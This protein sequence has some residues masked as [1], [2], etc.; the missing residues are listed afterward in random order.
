M[1]HNNNTKIQNN[2]KCYNT[3][4]YVYID[5]PLEKEDQI[6]VMG[7]KVIPFEASINSTSFNLDVSNDYNN[8]DR[9]SSII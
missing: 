2:K 6:R 7:L 8:I 9:C 1:N 5:N 4:F 3:S